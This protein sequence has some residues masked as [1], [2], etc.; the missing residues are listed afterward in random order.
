MNYD[1][2]IIG[3]GPA[4]MMA[5]GRAGELGSRV[6]LLEKNNRLGLKL[7]ATG[8]SRCNL[9]NKIENNKD[10]IANYGPNGKFLFSAFNKFGVKEVME[11]FESRGLELKVENN[12]RVFPKSDKAQDVLNVLLKYLRESK[13]EVVL[14]SELKKIIKQGNSIEKVILTD[15]RELKANNYLLAVGGKSYPETGSSGEIY[16]ILKDFGHTIIEPRPALAPLILKYKFIKD[17]QGLS[18]ADVLINVYQANKKIAFKR[19]ELLFTGDGLSGP[20]VINLSKI[21]GSALPNSV[22]L[23]LDFFPELN[24]KELDAKIQALFS[25]AKNK[26][27]KNTLSALVAPRLATLIINLAKID[28]T[29]PVNLITRE[30][31]SRL[32]NLLKEFKLEVKALAGFDKAMVT[33]GGVALNEVDPQTMKSKIIDNLFFSGEVLDLDGPTGG[34]NL[35]IAWSTGHL[36]GENL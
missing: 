31:R 36:A 9:T 28:L 17:L 25:D 13:V 7:L 26:L 14:N 34:F 21:I 15:G 30:E 4:G 19:G 12:N 23:K 8:G 32:I 11:F 29:K 35:Q 22:E 16:K 27:L 2:A 6:I 3:G 5:G 1:L 18:L 33:A 10:L 24:L 20:A